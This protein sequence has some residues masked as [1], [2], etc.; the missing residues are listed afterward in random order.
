MANEPKPAKPAQTAAAPPKTSSNILER[1][2]SEVEGMDKAALAAQV[3]KIKEQRAKA[4]AYTSQRN[5]TPEQKE[6]AKARA[7]EYMNRPEV[8]AKMKAYIQRPDVR[9]RMKA[10]AKE[11]RE[12]TKL[13]LQKARELGLEV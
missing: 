11:K 10:K 6:K 9:E 3:A 4:R 1:I 2:R 5:M 12:K 7:K 13:I 8:K